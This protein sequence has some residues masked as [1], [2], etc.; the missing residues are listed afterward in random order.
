MKAAALVRVLGQ[1]P[2]VVKIRQAGQDLGHRIRVLLLKN[3]NLIHYRELGH[4][5]DVPRKPLHGH[6]KNQELR[7]LV[8]GQLWHLAHNFFLDV[9]QYQLQL[10]C[11][12]WHLQ[13]QLRARRYVVDQGKCVNLLAQLAV[14]DLGGQLPQERHRLRGVRQRQ[15]YD[16]ALVGEYLI[17]LSIPQLGSQARHYFFCQLAVLY[18]L[19]ELAHA[20]QQEAELVNRHSL[21]PADNLLPDVRAE[22]GKLLRANLPLFFKVNLGDCVGA[23]HEVGIFHLV[24]KLVEYFEHTLVAAV[25]CQRNVA[26]GG[27]ELKFAHLLNVLGDY[28]RCDDLLGHK[29]HL[30]QLLRRGNVVLD[31]IQVLLFCQIL[32]LHSPP[33]A[34]SDVVVTIFVKN[35]GLVFPDL[36]HHPDL[37]QLALLRFRGLNDELLEKVLEDIEIHIFQLVRNQIKP[38]FLKY[39]QVVAVFLLAVCQNQSRLPIAWRALRRW[40]LRKLMLLGSR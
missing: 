17:D 13:H 32:E 35:H 5:H 36:I 14:L 34:Q 12:L 37:L 27:I 4:A 39:I 15:V 19:L 8:H 26:G 18:Q 9:G 3:L 16:Y 23:I 24:H 31:I 2:V 25:V 40:L 22:A 21:P 7:N 29:V 28:G 1:L 10:L 20:T 38:H 6:S 30:K 11:R 33:D